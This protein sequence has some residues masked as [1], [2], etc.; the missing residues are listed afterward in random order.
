MERKKRERKGREAGSQEREKEKLQPRKKKEEL[1]PSVAVSCRRCKRRFRNSK[2]PDTVFR[3]DFDSD[4]KNIFW[5][6]V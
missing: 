1:P 4:L 2:S 6:L 3:I 5:N